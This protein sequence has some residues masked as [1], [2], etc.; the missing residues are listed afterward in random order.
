MSKAIVVRQGVRQRVR[1]RPFVEEVNDVMG[2]TGDFG[3]MK[4]EESKQSNQLEP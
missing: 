3:V 4:S 2:G 1:R